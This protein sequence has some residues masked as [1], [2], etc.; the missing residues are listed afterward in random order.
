VAFGKIAQAVSSL[1]AHI[2]NRSNPHGVTAAQIGAAAAVH[3]HIASS[4]SETTDRK[5]MTAAERTKLASLAGVV[6][7]TASLQQQ[8][9]LYYLTAEEKARLA[10]V[11]SAGQIPI[12]VHDTN[13]V[14]YYYKTMY[15]SGNLVNVL[16]FE[17]VVSTSGYSETKSW[18]VDRSAGSSAAVIAVL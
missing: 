8:T 10:A 17:T 13:A 2:G 6:P 18:I 9:G 7:I 3:S 5:W 1:I 15:T 16:F 4:V 12:L 11:I 14:C